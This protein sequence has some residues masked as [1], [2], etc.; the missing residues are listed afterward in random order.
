MENFNLKSLV[1]PNIAALAPY[2]TARDEYKGRPGIFLDANESP[3]ENGYNRYPDPTQKELKEAIQ[4]IKGLPDKNIFIGNGSDEAIDLIFRIFCIPGKDNVIT[5]S[6]SYGMYRVAAATNDIQVK[7]VILGDGF[8]FP[9]KKILDTIDK[10]TKAIFLCSPNNPTGNSFPMEEMLS[11]AEKFKGIVVIDEAYID[12]AQVPSA[13][14]FIDEYP[15]I[16]VLQTLSKAWGMAGL[17]VGM[18][19]AQPKIIELMSMVK[20]PYNINVATIRIALSLLRKGIDGEIAQIKEEREKMSRILTA[21]DTVEK[22]FPSDANFLL[23][24]VNDADA[25]YSYLIG[26]GIIVRNR[27]SV[28][29]CA[30]CLRISIGTPEENARLLKAMKLYGTPEGCTLETAEPAMRRAI[31]SRKTK[32]T[33]ITVEIDLDGGGKKTIDTGLKFFDHMLQQIPHHSGI[34]L[35]VKCTGDLEVDEHHTMEDVAIVLGEAIR[36]ALGNKMGIERY[37]FVLP[38]DECRAMVLLDFGGRADFQW[39]VPFTREMVGDVPTEMFKHFFKTL[40]IAMK[41]NLHIEAKGENNHHL[42]E[43]VFKA[44]ARSIKMA[45]NRDPFKYTL[46]SSKGII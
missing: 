1:R 8:H 28:P 23:V 37:G 31:I 26:K 22:V 17:R 13:C 42:I 20:Y 44:F 30:G 39:D 15:N 40:C 19:F 6:P 5:I 27:N 25:L 21:I 41:A 11:I 10:D 3:Y 35:G 24:K 34:S 14:G 18:A 2:S 32:E 9:Y 46:P 33:C 12:F 43:G 45:I 38:M 16:I 4:K 7:E 36:K 29:G